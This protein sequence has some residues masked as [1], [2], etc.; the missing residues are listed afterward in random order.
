MLQE[1]G[2]IDGTSADQSGLN[3]D[4][5]LRFVQQLRSYLTAEEQQELFE[6]ESQRP[7]AV[8][9]YLAVYA[10]LARGFA[11]RQPGLIQRS[12]LLLQRLGGRQDVN[13]EQAVC[14]LLLGQ[15]ELASRSLEQSQEYESIAFIREHSQNSPDLLPGLCLYAERWLQ[16]EVF[17]HFRDLAN[18][19]AALKEYFADRQVQEYLE[20]L[21]PSPVAEEAV[22]PAVAWRSVAQ[23]STVG[24]S[25]APRSQP[26][27]VLEAEAAQRNLQP[28]SDE[29]DSPDTLVE[30]ARARIAARSLAG[31]ER[32]NGSVATMAAA[33]RVEPTQAGS[34]ARRGDHG[35]NASRSD[36]SAERGD[37]DAGRPAR[38]GSKPSRLLI[39]LIIFGVVTFGAGVAWALRN[40]QASTAP[41]VAEKPLPAISPSVSPS[42]TVGPKP[43]PAA[44]LTEQ[45]SQELLQSWLAAKAA[46]MGQKHDIDQLDR[47]LLEPKLSYWKSQAQLVNRDRSYIVYKH[48]IVKVSSVDQSKEKPD[49]AKVVAEVSEIR[50]EYDEAGKLRNSA[51]DQNL[52]IRYSLVRQNSGWR[53]QDWEV[54]S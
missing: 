18:R 26:A 27:V 38:P 23:S 46:A 40:W 39:P 7:S 20:T 45:T 8:A 30:V 48:D 10:L 11:E 51:K 37:G 50:E 43:S 9:T 52:K 31:S 15:T 28:H 44:T 2:G 35:R 36:S 5:F 24:A 47:V 22:V 13:L 33:E 32:S 3:V 54:L 19:R 29:H 1:R 6:A 12:N 21:P 42:A 53:I 4:D 16:E 49:Q 25:A 41:I 34:R 17:P 14:T